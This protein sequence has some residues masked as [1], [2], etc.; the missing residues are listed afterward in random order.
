MAWLNQKNLV[1]IPDSARRKPGGKSL[2]FQYLSLEHTLGDDDEAALENTLT[3]PLAD[4]PAELAA[5][6]D[7]IKK[8][9]AV[10]ETLPP[11][12][13]DALRLRYVDKVILEEIGARLGKSRC[14]VAI[15]VKRF[16]KRFN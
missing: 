15:A 13:Q 11:D 5:R 2:R 8:V 9:R 14:F 6:A 4:D 12:Y 10:L 1:R 7:D 16:K 3:E